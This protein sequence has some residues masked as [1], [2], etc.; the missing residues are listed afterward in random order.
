MAAQ[1]DK[2]ARDIHRPVQV[3]PGQIAPEESA[4]DA[5]QGKTL[6]VMRYVLAISLSLVIA[7]FLIAYFLTRAPAA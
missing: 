4:Q 7:A 3:P 6:G 2:H 5:R 1:T